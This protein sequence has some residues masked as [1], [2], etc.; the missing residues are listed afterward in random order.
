MV[1]ERGKVEVAE[2]AAAFGVSAMTIRRD[3]AELAARGLIDRTYGGAVIQRPTAVEPTYNEKVRL[4]AEEKDRIGRAAAEL[5]TDGDTLIL[6]AGSTTLA[7]A[8]HLKGKRDLTVVTNDLLIACELVPV[9]GIRV[10]L[11]GGICRPDF[12]CTVGLPCEEL[13][14]QISANK[15]FL[16]ADAVD[17]ERGVTNATWEEVPVKRLMMQAAQQVVLVADHSKFGWAALALVARLDE[18][19]QIITDSGLADDVAEQVA[20]AGPRVLRV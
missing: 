13:L 15:L 16:G 20:A 19:D 12:F 8:R 4:H 18:I 9:H 5:V 3:L 14:R 11:A 6:D 17:A 1:Q 2:L 7:V 10:I